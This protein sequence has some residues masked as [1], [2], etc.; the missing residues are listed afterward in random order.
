MK[1]KKNH[2]SNYINRTELFLELNRVR[3][4]DMVGK[5]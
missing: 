4:E 2:I 3:E 1:R 5:K